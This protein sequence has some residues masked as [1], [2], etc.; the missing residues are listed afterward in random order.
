MPLE[1]I[2]FWSVTDP[3]TKTPIALFQQT[4]ANLEWV[5]IWVANHCPHANIEDYTIQ[6]KR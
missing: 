5:Q 6:I 1:N 3:Q 2:K 4:F